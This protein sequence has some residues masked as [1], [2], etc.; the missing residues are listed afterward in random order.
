MARVGKAGPFFV[1][2]IGGDV[3]L[4]GCGVREGFLRSFEEKMSG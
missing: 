3:T 2:G 1:H 4:A